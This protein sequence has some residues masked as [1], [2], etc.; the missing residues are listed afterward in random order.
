MLRPHQSLAEMALPGAGDPDAVVI[1]AALVGSGEVVGSAAVTPE[2]VNEPLASVVPPGRQ[3]RLRSM[4]TREDLRSGGIGAAVM[5]ALVDHVA[6]RGG[7]VLW[8]HARTPAV[9]FYEREGF[10]PCGEAFDE[11]AIGPH[12]LMWRTVGAK[13]AAK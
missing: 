10:A 4:A 9:A 13:E 8:C 7:G 2:V 12:I 3:W 5:G 6:S 1:G 11:E